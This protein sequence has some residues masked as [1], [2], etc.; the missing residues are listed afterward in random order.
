MLQNIHETIHKRLSDIFSDKS[1]EYITSTII[2]HTHR[3]NDARILLL[4]PG[5]R[6][7]IT[8]YM[9]S[10]DGHTLIVT[11]AH[12]QSEVLQQHIINNDSV[13]QSSVHDSGTHIP[14]IIIPSPENIPSEKSEALDFLSNNS[15]RND[16][17]KAVRIE[18]TP[19]RLNLRIVEANHEIMPIEGSFK[20]IP[21]DPFQEEASMITALN[22]PSDTQ[23]V[24]AI[25][26]MWINEAGDVQGLYKLLA[27]PVKNLPA[28]VSL[29]SYRLSV[30]QLKNDELHNQIRKLSFDILGSKVDKERLQRWEEKSPLFIVTSAV[31]ESI[32]GECDQS[33]FDDIVIH[34]EEP[35]L[36]RKIDRKHELVFPHPDNPEIEI[37]V[38]E[39][40]C[41]S[42][43]TFV[44][45]SGKKE[46]EVENSVKPTVKETERP[47]KQVCYNYQQCCLNTHT[48]PTIGR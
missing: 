38:I 28:E 20:A 23:E 19:E 9:N 15:R 46:I 3:G 6:E 8:D 32:D 12:L 25:A 7:S 11:T 33:D 22:Y 40:G 27:G 41:P 17:H 18:I 30:H 34:P 26:M 29:D 44:H 39:P 21:A 4:A 10:D 2:T 48:W 42:K 16:A 43:V 35:S 36:K 31:P 24:T 37:Q 1:K 5:L 45:P 13:T 14:Y 47:A